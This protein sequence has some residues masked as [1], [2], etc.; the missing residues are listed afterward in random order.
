MTAIPEG[1]G[2]LFIDDLTLAVSGAA[3]K[4]GLNCRAV[5]GV[6]DDMMG[7]WVIHRLGQFGTDTSTIQRESGWRTSSSI[8]T[9][10]TDGQR[11]ALHM[12]G[13]T[14]AFYV[15]DALMP[16]V[17]DARAVHLGGVGL[18]DAMDNA[19]MRSSPARRR[20]PAP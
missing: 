5:G 16:A 20:Q 7:D 9:T 4:M 13:A 2:T 17:I 19:A 8:V 6:G 14:G 1:G 15:D 11:P 18:M 3:A 12:K 10:R